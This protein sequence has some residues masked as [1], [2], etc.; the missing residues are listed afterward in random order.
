MR[1]DHCPV[2]VCRG[3][4]FALWTLVGWTGSGCAGTQRSTRPTPEVRRPAVFQVT[5]ENF[6]EVLRELDETSPSPSS[7]PLR[8]ASARY[9]AS[10]GLER[11]Q[12]GDIEGAIR[13]LHRALVYYTP[14]ELGRGGLPGEL[15]PLARGVIDLVSPRGDEAHALAAYRV[16]AAT[17]PPDPTAMEHFQQIHT[18]GDRNRA[19]FRPPWV[20]LGEMADI[21]KEVA[22][23]VPAPD[24]LQRTVELLM[25]RRQAAL[26]ARTTPPSPSR[27]WT[28]EDMRQ[29]QAGLSNTPMDLAMVFLRL[30]DIQAAADH[31]ERLAAARGGARE[32]GL[33]SVLRSI[34]AGEGGAD[35]MAELAAQLERLDLGAT[36]G[37]CRQ[38]RR[39]YPHDARFAQCLAVAAAREG[40]LGLASAHFETAAQ[41]QPDDSQL[42]RRALSTTLQWFDGE[43]RNEDPLPGRRALTRARALLDRWHQRFPRE[44]LPIGIGDLEEMGGSLELRHGNLEAAQQ[45]LERATQAHPPSR[46]AYLTL[47]EIAWR[48]GNGRR[49]IELLE[50]GLALPLRPTES[51][52]TFRPLFQLRLG[53]AARVSGDEALARRYFTQAEASFDALTRSL[54]GLGKGRSFFFRAVALEALG[55]TDQI[56][57]NLDAAINAAPDSQD[58]AALVVTFALGRGRWQDAYEIA[59]A[60]RGRLSLDQTWQAYFAL[61]EAIAARLG[62]FE[63]NGHGSANDALETIASTANE[64]SPWTVRLAQRFRGSLRRDDLLHFAQSP[65]QRA[66]AY[67]YEAMLE[68]ASGDL[69]AAERDLR[70]VLRTEILSFFEYD[71]AWEMLARGLANLRRASPPAIAAPANG[72]P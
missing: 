53:Q 17:S 61:W 48:H 4:F 11:I 13:A 8:D 37:V 40:Q 2:A 33:A 72:T 65:G 10:R 70:A 63:Q 45:H 41:L 39:Q 32:G 50:Q 21:Y 38:G 67:F 44:P 43:M 59:R 22:R 58:L 18:W 16:L 66:E 14:E 1:A 49:A 12:E 47:A 6:T 3:L 24:V 51:D 28:M 26:E 52:S 29:L 5:G 68:L 46:D 56:R 23:I 42:L 7:R 57:R 25:A 71:M 69:D 36:A 19:E 30:G 34:A 62:G 31:V 20:H 64:H 35:G 60:A 27:R 15:A 55:Q 9:Q 54:D